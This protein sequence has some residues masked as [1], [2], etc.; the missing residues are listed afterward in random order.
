MLKLKNVNEKE[1]FIMSTNSFKELQKG[2]KALKEIESSQNRIFEYLNNKKIGYEPKCKICNSKYQKEVEAARE[3]GYTLEEM[4]DF[5]SENGEDV[6]IMSLSR[7][8]ERHYPARKEYLKGLDDEK[9]KKIIEGEKEI[10]KVLKYDPEFEE[11]LESN[12]TYYGYDK[13]GVFKD[14]TKKG[15]DIFIFEFG[16]CITKRDFC[17]LV[18]KLQR[19]VGNEITDNLEFK[20]RQINNG[21]IND[22]MGEKL[23]KTVEEILECTNCQAFYHECITHGLLNLILNERY[24]V[25]MEPEEFNDICFESDFI[26][27]DMDKKIKK[28]AAKKRDKDFKKS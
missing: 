9:S 14:Y 6:S 27:E 24:G 18:P 22:F 10:K 4:K 21:H 20:I 3:E 28:Y 16:Y 2:F 11:E 17:K 23:N 8:F 12:H 19:C 25:E 1:E 5:L 15:R 13:N 26:Y 7:H